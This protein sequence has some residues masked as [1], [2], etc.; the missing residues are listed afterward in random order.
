MGEVFE[1]I[2]P[3]THF[4]VA[5]TIC[6]NKGWFPSVQ[7][8]NN[9]GYIRLV[10]DLGGYSQVLSGLLGECTLTQAQINCLYDVG[11]NINKIM[12]R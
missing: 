10:T 6:K 11:V 7:T 8:L 2:V 12:P 5:E 9:L 1:V 4:R 3:G